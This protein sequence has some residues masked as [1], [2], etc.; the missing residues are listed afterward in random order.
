VEPGGKDLDVSVVHYALGA[1][2]FLERGR[3]LVVE[4]PRPVL[5][6]AADHVVES[7]LQ[8]SSLL[9]GET[10]PLVLAPAAARARR[11]PRDRDATHL[12]SP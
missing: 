11:V 6:T 7:R 5:D 4:R 12:E 8:H 3:N 9:V 10:A 1:D 2:E